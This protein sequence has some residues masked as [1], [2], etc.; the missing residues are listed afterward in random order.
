MKHS[1]E[2]EDESPIRQNAYRTSPMKAKVIRKE[3]AK[4]LELGVFRES[5]SHFSSPVVIVPKPMEPNVYLLTSE[6]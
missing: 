2:L 5:D 3:I 1:I 6:D 4:L